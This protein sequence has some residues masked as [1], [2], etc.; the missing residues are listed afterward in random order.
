MN[1]LHIAVTANWLVQ[2]GASVRLLRRPFQQ[3]RKIKKSLTTP[4]AL[5][6]SVRASSD[7]KLARVGCEEA[8]F[9]LFL[10]VWPAFLLFL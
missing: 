4:E 5:L 2:P 3:S 6:L 1:L 9:A 8:H 10:S 7:P